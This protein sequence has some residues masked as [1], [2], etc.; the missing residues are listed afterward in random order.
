[1]TAPDWC[2]DAHAAHPH[3]V[4]EVAVPTREAD[5]HEWR[6]TF[7]PHMKLS[8]LSTA[9][10][11]KPSL[12]FLATFAAQIAFLDQPKRALRVLRDERL[13]HAYQLAIQRVAEGA[14][15][16]LDA[17]CTVKPDA[18]WRMAGHSIAVFEAGGGVLPVMCA[19]AGARCVTGA[20][21]A[22]ASLAALLTVAMAAYERSD[23]LAQMAKQTIAANSQVPGAADVAVKVTARAMQEAADA[24][25]ADVV[26]C[27]ACARAFGHKEPSDSNPNIQTCSTTRYWAC[28]S[29]RSSAP[30]SP[31]AWWRPTPSSFLERA[32]CSACS[33]SCGWTGFVALT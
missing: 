19:G 18:K 4:S 12:R 21:P 2:V 23:L 6:P 27:G 33:S 20:S 17:R 15:C 30:R 3:G 7:M 8:A 10:F 32:V 28:A 26:V 9:E 11:S 31:P 1:M 25:A 5:D 24:P 13:M 16:R 22:A 14:Q 29:C